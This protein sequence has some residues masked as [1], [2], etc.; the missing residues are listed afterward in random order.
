MTTMLITFEFAFINGFCLCCGVCVRVR[1]D[2]LFSLSTDDKRIEFRSSQDGFGHSFFCFAEF[3]FLHLCNGQ[4]R[5]NCKLVVI[6]AAGCPQFHFNCFHSN[7][8][9]SRLFACF[10]V[11][12]SLSLAPSLILSF[13]FCVTEIESVLWVVR[14]LFRNV[15]MKVAKETRFRLH[16]RSCVHSESVCFGSCAMSNVRSNNTS[17]WRSENEM[18]KT[19][20]RLIVVDVDDKMKLEMDFNLSIDTHWFHNLFR[21]FAL[22]LYITRSMD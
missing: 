22:S 15:R 8:L 17:K 14:R 11:T 18:E 7:S 1:P 10:F 16:A 6:A 21:S 19:K 12:L 9:C 5:V 4:I 2:R 13:F 3:S 20:R